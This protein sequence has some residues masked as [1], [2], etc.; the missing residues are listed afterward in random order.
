MP[1][2]DRLNVA[3]QSRMTALTRA[4]ISLGMTAALAVMALGAFVLADARQ[5]TWA[6]AEHA[7][8]NLILA[9]ERD[10]ARNVAVYDLS[11]QGAIDSIHQPGIDEVSPA[12]RHSAVFDRAATASHLGSILVLDRTGT[13]KL[14]STA[15]APHPLNLSDRDYFKV[16]VDRPDAGLFVSRVFRSRLRGGDPSIAISRRIS[17]PGGEFEGVVVGTLRLAYFAQPIR[18]AGCGGAWVGNAAQHRG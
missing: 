11:L 2:D 7:S 13:I 18:E 14:D 4:L 9:L 3:Q 1:D 15:M 17:G 12:I 5:D 10:I 16:H 6:Q 8:Q